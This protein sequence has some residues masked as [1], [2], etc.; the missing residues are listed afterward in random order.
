MADWLV[1]YQ[2]QESDGQSPDYLGGYP[3]GATPTISTATYTEA[4]I[5]ACDLACELGEDQRAY[6]FR[7]ASILGLSF[8]Q[9]LQIKD[10]ETFWLPNPSRVV[11]GLTQSL[12]SFQMR[13][14]FDQ[15]AITCWISALE[16]WE[17]LTNG[18]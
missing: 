10:S 7:R 15:H 6:T 3:V 11:G 14:D 12:T 18:Q 2:Y 17:C 1:R 4:L 13:N 5:Y 16:N 8:L 9:R